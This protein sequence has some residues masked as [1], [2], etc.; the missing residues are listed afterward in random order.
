MGQIAWL[1]PFDL[2]ESLSETRLERQ[3][4]T[5]EHRC[6]HGICVQLRLLDGRLVETT[7]MVKQGNG[8]ALQS[9]RR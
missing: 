5:D 6:L 9:R 4:D 1:R 3:M 8:P 2:M 7:S